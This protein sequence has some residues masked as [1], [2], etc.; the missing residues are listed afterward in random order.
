MTFDEL[1]AE[2]QEKVKACTTP[3]EIQALAKEE[4]YELS[5]NDLDA[6]AGGAWEFRGR[7]D[8]CPDQRGPAGT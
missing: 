7:K 4:G 3:E 2:L 8:I 1:S 5:D 6:I